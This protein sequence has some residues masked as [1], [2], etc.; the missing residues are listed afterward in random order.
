M[1][2][3]I[4]PRLRFIEPQPA[5]PV[6]QP[7]EGRHWIHEI[8]HDGYRTLVPAQCVDFLRRDCRQVAVTLMPV[9][10]S[11]AAAQPLA[12]VVDLNERL[13]AL[14]AITAIDFADMA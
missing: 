3:E 7:P 10:A 4:H 8:K 14:T 11:Y 13:F 9:I 6:D 5:S 1:P 12:T 2:R